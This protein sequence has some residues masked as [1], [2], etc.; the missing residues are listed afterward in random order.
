VKSIASVGQSLWLDY[1]RRDLLDSGRLASMVEDDGICGV[2]S[3]PTIFQKAIA[4]STLYDAD[5]RELAGRGPT[6]ALQVYEVLAVEDVRRASDVLRT[7]Y[8]L[9]AGADGYVS[10]EVA[11][12]LA[13]DGRGL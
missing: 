10:L 9:T 13:H 8:D 5:I 2:T 7:V 4:G 3:N 11:P 6:T 1:I 12:G